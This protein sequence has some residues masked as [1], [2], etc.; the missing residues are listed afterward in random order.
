MHFCPTVAGE[1]VAKGQEIKLGN[2]WRTVTALLGAPQGGTQLVM[3]ADGAGNERMA[4]VL[5]NGRYPVRRGAIP[6]DQRFR[7]YET[8]AIY[9]RNRDH[10]G[11]VYVIE[12]DGGPLVRVAWK[13]NALGGGRTAPRADGGPEPA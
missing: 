2:R 8:S 12:D 3:T 1:K 10:M 11:I 9:N 13:T 5:L 4:K 7:F 6:P